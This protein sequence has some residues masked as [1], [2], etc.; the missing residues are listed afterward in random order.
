[1]EM[2]RGITLI[3][4]M[5]ALAVFAIV[6]LPLARLYTASLD[7]VRFSENYLMALRLANERME[8][9]R[10]LFSENLY[11]GGPVMD[12]D[13]CAA[14]PFEVDYSVWPP[15][16]ARQ[17]NRVRTQLGNGPVEGEPR[18]NP[19]CPMYTPSVLPSGNPF[20]YYADNAFIVLDSSNLPFN[21]EQAVN[22][23]N[24][25]YDQSQL[26]L[27][28]I[29]AR[30]D[31]FDAFAIYYNR[32]MMNPTAR[33]DGIEDFGH[34]LDR[35]FLQ[36]APLVTVQQPSSAC[37]YTQQDSHAWY[38]F[39]YERG[40]GTFEDPDSCI[41]EWVFAPRLLCG[42]GGCSP[43]QL[44]QYQDAL[45]RATQA[46]AI[47][48]RETEITNVFFAG[49]DPDGDGVLEPSEYPNWWQYFYISSHPRDLRNRIYG[50]LV[51]V[52]VMWKTGKTQALP[53]EQTGGILKAGELV[54]Q[55]QL[56]EFIPDPDNDP[57]DS[58]YPRNSAHYELDPFVAHGAQ[59]PRPLTELVHNQERYDFE[60]KGT[61]NLA[62]R[63]L[64]NPDH[65]VTPQCV[66]R[67]P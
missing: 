3:E 67:N 29:A 18:D 51:R 6:V 14:T 56:T 49:D 17:Y 23:I 4:V 22:T 20:Q 1:M 59:A 40:V 26:V 5:V 36:K 24:Q 11:P 33:I 39:G 27:A 16:P 66:I 34:I 64:N 15:R 31:L 48:R 61:T 12:F 13:G 30:L 38:E 21:N 60:Y 50:R 46:F 63:R 55:V 58:F 47:F 28:T 57:C 32:Q 37:S 2:K 8:E 42:S 43:Q 9:V 19:D 54:K 25:G 62:R 65:W 35:D 52:T 7:V 45:I 53:F 41:R 44:A 10:T